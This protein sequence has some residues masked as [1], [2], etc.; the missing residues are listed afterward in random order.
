MKKLVIVFFSLFYNLNAQILP[1]S[2]STNTQKEWKV[3][4]FEERYFVQNKG[5]WENKKVNNQE[6]LFAFDGQNEDYFFTKSGVQIELIKKKWIK[7]EEEKEYEKNHKWEEEEYILSEKRESVYGEWIG[8][9]NNVEII[10]LDKNSYYSSYT[11]KKNN[12]YININFIPTFKKLLYKNIYPNID[13]EYTLHPEGGFKYN[14]II[15][16]GGDI[17]KVK[18]RYFK[19][20]KLSN[21]KIITSTRFGNIIDHTPYAYYENSQKNISCEYVLQDNIISFK[22]DNVNANETIIIDPWTQTPNFPSTNWDCVWE[23]ERDGAGNV[24]IIGGTSPMQLIKYNSTGTLQWTY[25]TPYDT[26]S[27]L[28]TFAVDNAGNSYVTQGSTAQIQKINTA[29]SLVWNNTSPVAMNSAEFW[30]ISFNCNQSKLVVA[31]TSLPFLSTT[32]LPFIYNVD[33]N[34]GNVTASVQVTGP[35]GLFSPGPQEVRAITSC[36]NANYYYLTHDSIG[37]I[38]DNLISCN[39]NSPF[40]T[41]MANGIQFGY[42]CENF[43]KNNTGL[44]ALAYSNFNGFVYLNKGDQVQKRDFATGAVVATANIPGGVLSGG[45]GNRQADNS[46]IS[47][48]NCGN[49]YVGSTNGVYKFDANLNPLGSYP[50]SFNVYD[51]EVNS[52]GEVIAAG[53]TG[54]SGSASRTGYVQTFAASACAPQSLICCDPNICPPPQKCVNDPPFTFS[55]STPGGTFSA[56]CGSCINSSTGSF[57]PSV[58]GSG[59]FVVTYSLS[60]GSQT[61]QVV[62]APCATLN[63]C[64]LPSGSLQVSGGTPSYTWSYQ[65][66]SVNC[67]G[68]TIGCTFPPG[69]S[70]TVNYW[71]N[72][73][74][75]SVT[76]APPNFPIRIT[77]ATGSTIQI[78]SAASVTPCTSCPTIVIT[79]TVQNALCYGGTGSATVSASGG[80]GP[81]TYTWMPGSLTGSVQTSLSP[82]TI[83]TV[84][85]KD[86][87]SCT[88]TITI[89]ITQPSSLT[90]TFSNQN[91]ICTASNGSSTISVSG[92]T[93]PYTYTWLPTGG[94]SSVATN[95]SAGNYSVIVKDA[96]NCSV[97]FTNSISSN[98]VIINTSVNIQNASC[99]AAGSATVTPSGGTPAYNYTW[100][101]TGGSSSVATGLSIGNYTVNISDANGCNTFT[102]LTIG[103]TGIAIA[104]IQ[105]QSVSC[106]NGN[107]GSATVSVTGG[108][109]PYSY[110]WSPSVS[111]SSVAN[112]LSAGSYTVFIQDNAACT[113]STVVNITQP[114]DFTITSVT[115]SVTCNGGNNGSATIT[116][117]GGNPA[118]SYTW[119]PTGGNSNI[120]NNLSAGNYTISILDA[121]SCATVY[122]LNITEPPA[123]TVNITST[124]NCGANAT[125]TANVSGGTSPYTYTWLP[126]GGN[127]QIA[128]NLSPG[129]YTLLVNDNNGCSS[130]STFTVSST[131]LSYTITTD[132]VDCYGGANGSAT[133]SVQGGLSPYSFTW[134][135]S[136]GNS[137]IANN[138]SAG[139]YTI[140]ISDATG[141]NA[142]A[143][144]S[145]S[146]PNPITLNVTSTYSICSSNTITLNASATGGNGNYS[147]NWNPGS[148][149]NNGTLNVSPSSTTIYSVSATDIKGC[150]S[151]VYTIQVYVYPI[152]SANGNTITVCDNSNIILSPTIT[153]AGNGGPYSYT[154]NTGANTPSI[155]VT[156]NYATQPQNYTVTISDGCNSP[157]NAYFT[158]SVS[159]T[160]VSTFTSD[161]TKGCLPLNV[162]FT[163]NNYNPSYTY[164]W[165]FGNGQSATGYSVSTTY[166]NVGYYDV[167]L[168]VSNSG[169][170]STTTYSNYIQVYPNPIADYEANPWIT[171]EFAPTVSFTSTSQ[172]ATTYNWF[173]SD[174]GSGPNNTSN[175]QNPIHT[176]TQPGTYSV[177]L[178]VYNQYGCRDMVVKTI[179]VEPEF[180][181]YIPD[182]F[183]PDGNNINDVFLVKG[184][185]I[186]VTKF[187]ML[188]FDRWGELIF[189]TTDFYEGWDGTVRGK[190][191]KATQDVYV[192]KIKV[193]DLKGN[194]HEYVGHITCLPGTDEF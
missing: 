100:I 95:I 109:T 102:T 56:S 85:A 89:S 167:S 152:L 117:N 107:N 44:E 149:V 150:T 124:N 188:I 50:T 37:F 114:G 103:G 31:G 38:H 57:S 63:V 192:Y 128:S 174:F 24:Y 35:G 130:S 104:G 125:A 16:P 180:H 98:T 20:S 136:G 139:N 2:S 46:G 10:P 82:G 67:S 151:N 112:N 133:I 120:A 94:N 77:D 101:P 71:A 3:Q 173:F 5:Q 142:T 1:L 115:N 176:F 51:V 168:T 127:S 33:V 15:H 62:V 83:Y 96:N 141:C 185:G 116:V 9:N 74:T 162:I 193:Y 108:N 72:Y 6:I 131:N 113:A 45:A 189:K 4:P 84:T 171:T 70:V 169:C 25:N 11:F 159:P 60:C 23:C 147:F 27:W 41:H 105:T 49:V 91:A 7:K 34:T 194:K 154:W 156:A 68:C 66:S 157:V 138:L 129:N 111:S 58:S 183:T 14:I 42:K 126:T 158:V 26:T 36:S 184:M 134:S 179:V 175:L 160:P 172:G 163:A 132:S 29:G 178:V 148:I 143:T 48:D 123:L 53:S 86:N 19:K 8:I 161:F 59:T 40:P 30:N 18:F 190:K 140:T 28:G 80:T 165:N 164:T 153:S 145:I 121:N 110:T 119:A 39:P 73:A 106:F 122:T 88:G 99:S 13:I 78:N 54:N 170:S 69:C 79:P 52:G 187:E 155:S 12:K 21:N 137:N 191:K 81:Y 90:A 93:A 87:N 166:T 177:A 64:S 97:T 146:Q 182:A 55:V 32:P 43:R 181:I 17:T 135:P 118:Y 92:G 22:L 144:L 76:A 47:I 61:T 186:D 75:G 65:T